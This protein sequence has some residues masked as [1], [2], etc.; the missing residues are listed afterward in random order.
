MKNRDILREAKS[1]LEDKTLSDIEFGK[2]LSEHHTVLRDNLG[3]STEKI[4]RMLSSAIRAGA[5]GGKINGSGGG[6]CMFVYAPNSPEK[7]KAAIEA[8]G[9]KGYIVTIGKG[10]E[11]TVDGKRVI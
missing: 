5:L 3:I 11:A 10:M 1:K 9:G 4:E 7:V 2:L 6:G 8:E